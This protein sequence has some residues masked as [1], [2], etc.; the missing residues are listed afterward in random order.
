LLYHI[1]FSMCVG[2][3]PHSTDEA[4]NSIALSSP[5]L[6]VLPLKAECPAGEACIELVLPTLSVYVCEIG[7]K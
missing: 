1:L 2:F 4:R 5:G 3:Q 7:S 6:V